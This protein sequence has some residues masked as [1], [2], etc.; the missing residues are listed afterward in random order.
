MEHPS[1]YSLSLTFSSIVFFFD[2]GEQMKTIAILGSTGSIGTQALEVVRHLG[3]EYQIKA[4]AAGSNVDLLVEQALEFRPSVVA[5]Y[6]EKK[7]MELRERLPGVN[8]VSGMGG[9]QEVAA[10]DGVDLVISSIS[11]SVGLLP[12]L[13][14]IDAGKD[15]GLANKEALVCAGELV[16][17]RVKEKGVR[18]LP[19]DSEH[20][21]IFQCIA[22]NRLEDLDRIIL[23]ASGGPF[24]KRPANE[25]MEIEPEEALNHPTWQMGKKVTI[26]SATLMNKGLEVILVLLQTR[27]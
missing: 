13:T 1:L 21:A 9:L 18:L 19:I 16:M 14:A 4:L 8:V 12:T 26:D 22:G 7:V 10:C 17:K 6:D 15:I 2:E 20:S 5:I 11:G 3:E 24:L 27:T 23:T 25:F